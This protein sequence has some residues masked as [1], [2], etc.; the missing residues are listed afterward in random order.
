MGIYLAVFIHKDIRS[1]IKGSLKS[2][3]RHP[4]MVLIFCKQ[5]ALDPSWRRA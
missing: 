2:N 4:R 1:F 5:V 3:P